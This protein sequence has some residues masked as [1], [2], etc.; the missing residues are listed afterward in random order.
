MTGEPSPVRSH[1]VLDVSR[2]ERAGGWGRT[3]AGVA[4]VGLAM[5][6]VLAVPALVGVVAA[7]VG[8][9]ARAVIA[10]VGRGF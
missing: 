5:L 3:A 1:W 7:S 10:I 4:D 2:P 9:L 6:M 8:L